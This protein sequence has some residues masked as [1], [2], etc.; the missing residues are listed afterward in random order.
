MVH[1]YVFFCLCMS[2]SI[3]ETIHV[4]AQRMN[5]YFGEQQISERVEHVFD[6]LFTRFIWVVIVVTRALDTWRIGCLTYL[7]VGIVYKITQYMQITT[8][9]FIKISNFCFNRGIFRFIKVMYL[10]FLF[11]RNRNIIFISLK[12][13]LLNNYFIDTI[14]T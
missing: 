1:L 8:E 6:D 11:V 3:L 10:F 13:S 4:W 7:N 9:N 12:T 5:K 14:F 2:S